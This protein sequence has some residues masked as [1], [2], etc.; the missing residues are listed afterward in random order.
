MKS[1]SLTLSILGLSFV[2]FLSGGL[3]TYSWSNE[4]VREA[5]RSLEK[6]ARVYE[7]IKSQYVEEPDDS[8]LVDG[9]IRGMLQSLDEHSVYLTAQ[10]FKD[11][12]ED[13]R[14]RFGGLGIE[15]SMRNNQLTVVAPIEGT[16]AEKAGIL[17]GDVIAFIEDQPTSKMTLIEA[18]KLMRGEP[19]SK[20]TIR[21]KREGV[22]D[23][24][25]M[26]LKRAII[27]SRS[28]QAELKDNNIGVVRLRGFSERSSSELREAIRKFRNEIREKESASDLRALI[29][30][31]RSNPGGLLQQAVEVSDVFLREG[32]IVYTQGRDKQRVSRSFANSSGTEPDYPMVVLI[33]RGSASASEIVAGA[34]QDQKRARVIGTKSFGKA[35]VQHVIPLEDG[36][37]IKLTVAH[38]YTPSGRQIQ[39]E[40]IE[41]DQIV[42]GPFDRD[43]DEDSEERS[44]GEKRSEG[45]EA[46]TSEG[47]AQT[48]PPVDP[49]E[50]GDP[51]MDAAIEYLSRRLA[52]AR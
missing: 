14:G 27:Q 48:E 18:V 9:A 49:E 42:R 15:I 10:D 8:E 4:R 51:Q 32:L 1:K 11:M 25:R 39:G 37:G 44:E 6:F 38:Y 19:N 3:W 31:L 29:L 36:S 20:V 16:P 12:Q 30:D 45:P 33:N 46:P 52:M 26:S 2:A 17:S 40:G 23:L 34:L 24:I 5:Y 13:T 47:V 50:V 28:V 41:P 22:P 7:I 35:S 21:I 43:P